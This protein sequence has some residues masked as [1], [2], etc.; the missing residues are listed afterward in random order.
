[1]RDCTKP[2]NSE[3]HNPRRR[4]RRTSDVYELHGEYYG[5]EGGMESCHRHRFC[6][7]CIEKSSPEREGKREV[8]MR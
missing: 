4:R 6:S 1:M 7:R 2:C 3:I 8:E 5:R